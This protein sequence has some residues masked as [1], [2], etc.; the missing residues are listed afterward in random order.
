MS[1]DWTVYVQALVVAA[2]IAPIVEETMFRGV[3][4]RHLRDA[5]AAWGWL[6]SVILSATV[7][8]FIFAVAH[9][10]GV[11]TVPAYMALA[12]GFTIAREWRG[13]LIPAMLG[14]AVHNTLVA[15]FVF[16]A[17]G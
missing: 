11:A 12:Y 6:K 5:S 17:L 16:F 13:T 4:Y 2:V 15:T 1:G 10:L 9:V 8:S 7:V 3:L 14:H